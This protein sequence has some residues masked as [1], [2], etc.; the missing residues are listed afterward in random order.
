MEDSTEC[1]KAFTTRKLD[2]FLYH[3]SK[4]GSQI[5]HGCTETLKKN[6]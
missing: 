4:K 6:N 3:F 5:E 1:N 2:L